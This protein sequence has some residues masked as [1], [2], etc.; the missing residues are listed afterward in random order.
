MV[1]VLIK[2]IVQKNKAKE[3]NALFKKMHAMAVSQEGYVSAETFHNHE[4]PEEFLV[5]STWQNAD[6][7]F[8]WCN[9][10]DRTEIQEKIDK[11]LGS[12]TSYA[13]YNYGISD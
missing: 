10:S 3:L 4:Y 12:A 11:L 8:K 2:R 6:S 13:V 7:W 5:I 9:S 1:K